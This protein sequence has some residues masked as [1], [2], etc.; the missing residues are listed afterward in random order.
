MYKILIVVALALGLQGCATN[1][2]TFAAGAAIGGL[3]IAGAQSL[4]HK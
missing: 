1:A 4:W 2:E 3:A